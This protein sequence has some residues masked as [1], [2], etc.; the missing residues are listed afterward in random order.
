MADIAPFHVMEVQE[1][2]FRL[3]AAGRRIVHM[4]IGQPDFAA[5]PQVVEAAARAMRTERLG[6]TSAL[7]LMALR[8]AIARYYDDS[9]GVGISPQRIV[10]T[11]GASGAFI[12]ALSALVGPGDEV[13]MP[14][15]CYPCS[16]HM[17]RLFEGR[18]VDLAVDESTRY[19]P[20]A[21]QIGKAW[22]PATRGVLLASP[23][24]PT[25][26]SVARAE[27]ARIRDVVRQR[28]G[29]LL[30][31]EIYSGLWYD[32]KPETAV[33]LGDD[34]LVVNSFSKYFS[35]TGWRLGWMV[36]PEALVRDIETLAQNLYVSPPAPAQFAALAAFRS[37]T[38]A[39]LEER[40]L[41][42][43]RRRDFIVPALR[44]LGFSVPSTPDGAFYVY[45]GCE[46]HSDDSMG[47][48]LDALER[49]GV[50]LTPGVDFG[51]HGAS[52]HIRIAYTRSLEELALGVERLEGLV[53]ASGA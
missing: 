46:A 42:F 40:R 22:T 30:V 36:V 17:V 4:E 43:A 18:P 34:V 19:Q 29:F 20:T 11:T 3:E 41:E 9:L 8:E 28:R 16:R 31:D 53:R 5:P 23:A 33:S 13:I 51:R 10:I 7:G 50:A 38:L 25:G 12:L 52:R 14:D 37:D 39:L 15:P 44:S 45:A 32:A 35:M 48:A 24:N 49:G 47:F 1:R 27:L 2:A 6:Y 26:T 21:E